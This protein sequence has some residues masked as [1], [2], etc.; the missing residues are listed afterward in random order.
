MNE[1]VI[2][3]LKQVLGVAD[4]KNIALVRCTKGV[5]YIECDADL[6]WCVSLYNTRCVV[7]ILSFKWNIENIVNPKLVCLCVH[8][9]P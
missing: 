2:D 1:S 5:Q 3:L 4:P 7:N 8:A 9:R 6:T